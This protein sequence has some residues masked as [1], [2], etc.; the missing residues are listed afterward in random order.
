MME[1]PQHLPQADALLVEQTKV[2]DYLLNLSHKEGGPKA[3]FFLNRG[4][5]L[6]AW[7]LM[8]QALRQHGMTQPV[9]ETSET[10]FGRKFTVECQ[11][12]TPDG[13][14]PCILT[15]WIVEGK[16]PP[17]LVTAHPNS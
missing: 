3:K 12:L 14:N 5:R 13:R 8:A 1:A 2:Q 17:R 6:D 16:R 10:R 7:E 4:F 11:I 9:T 15:A